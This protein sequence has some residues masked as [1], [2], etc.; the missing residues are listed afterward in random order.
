M[1]LGKHVIIGY[2]HFFKNYITLMLCRSEKENETSQS[3]REY[4]K[5]YLIRDLN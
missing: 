4:V 3:L 5:N 2:G 1:Q